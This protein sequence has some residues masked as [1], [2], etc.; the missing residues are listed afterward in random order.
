MT[1][2]V[3]NEGRIPAEERV[4][5]LI[6]ALVASPQGLTKSELLSTVYGYAGRSSTK[7]S[8]S[9]LERQF[10]RDKDQVRALGIPIE[11][12]DSPQEP[13]NNQLT[14]YRIPKDR[15]QLPA[16]VRFT[17]EELT[18]LRL[19]SLAWA[20]GSLGSESRWAGM[21]L[22]ALGAGLDVRHLGIAPRL[23]MP[24]RAA[25]LLKRAIEEGRVVR[26]EYQLP[27]RD[28]PLERQVA[29][30]RLHRAE[31]RWHL[32]AY[33]IVREAQRV[34]LLSRI[35]SEV[36]VRQ[37]KFDPALLDGV[38]HSVD[39]LLQLKERQ[40]ALVV[41]RRGSAAEARLEQRGRPLGA[42]EVQPDAALL[43]SQVDAAILELGTLDWHALAD[44]LAGYGDEVQ[45][46]EPNSLR[47]LVVGRL[48][49]VRAQHT[50]S[51]SH[52]GGENA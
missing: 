49:G 23:G 30:L 37:D 43:V 33:D 24:D 35:V 39:Q 4:F 7:S 2:S 48:D 20:D 3:A 51:V 46:V 15:L 26:F 50:S 11:T 28:I 14:R 47:E 12:V 32:I 27:D 21:K 31:G 34:F 8:R 18:L 17:T 41:V 19:A 40:R 10:E 45:V 44:E 16:D 42:N 52:V 6:L 13:G 1:G 22:A 29:P 36:E 5:S 9:G 25:P 38:E